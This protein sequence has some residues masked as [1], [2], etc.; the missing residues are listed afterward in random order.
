MYDQLNIP[1]LGGSPGLVLL[2][3][4]SCSKG[5]GFESRHRK[6]DGLNIFSRIFVV[7]IVMF[8]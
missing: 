2:G 3:G 1:M 5:R 4:D 8:V 6:L 7:R